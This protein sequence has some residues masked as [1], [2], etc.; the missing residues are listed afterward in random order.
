VVAVDWSGAA[1]HAERRIWLAEALDGQRLLRLE[2]G[3]GRDEVAAHLLDE[4]ARTPRLVIGLDFCFG[5]PAWFSQRVLEANTGPLVWARVGQATDGWLTACPPPFWGRPGRPRPP[6]PRQPDLRWTEQAVSP[7]GGVHPKSVFQIGG[8]GSVGTGSLR[9]MALLDRLHRAGACV[10][11]FQAGGWPLVVEIYPRLLTGA[12][13]K[14]SPLAR[15]A[16][17][18]RVCPTLRPEH[19]QAAVAS[20]DAFDAALSALV[21]ARCLADLKALPPEPDARVRLEGRIWH[22]AWRQDRCLDGARA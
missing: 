12:V 8:A 4:A 6:A 3:R 22:P 14:S 1:V 15:Q 9:G 13:V 2:T 17:L 10:W 18:D 19:R 21:M 7:V 20:E 11:P 5:F 16:L